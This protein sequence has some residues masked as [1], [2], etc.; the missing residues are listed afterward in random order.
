MPVAR[1]HGFV[2]LRAPYARPWPAALR[3]ASP[4]R[5]QGPFPRR[6]R[7]AGNIHAMRRVPP[8][9]LAFLLATACAAPA[10]AFTM[11]DGKTVSCVA[12]GASVREYEAPATDPLMR[13]R[14]GMTF[15]ENGHYAIAWNLTKLNALP[16]AVHDFIFFHECAHARIPTTDELQANC[17]G[18][19]D[20]R[21][22]GRAG[23]AVEEALAAYF[24]AGNVYWE[25]TVKCADRPPPLPNPP[26]SVILKPP[27]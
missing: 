6:V 11:S 8:L 16:P 12:R 26:G 15:P 20:M 7:F 22:A 13:D 27:G 24:G 19:K 17:G 21:E 9:L 5:T 4:G 2:L 1:P 18:L 14:T 25:S 10:A 23:P 3:R